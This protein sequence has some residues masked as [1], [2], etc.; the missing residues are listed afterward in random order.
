MQCSL[1]TAALQPGRSHS[2]ARVKL[3]VRPLST[4]RPPTS[5]GH[6]EGT[7]EGTSDKPHLET[8]SSLKLTKKGLRIGGSSELLPNHF[9]L[10]RPAAVCGHSKIPQTSFCQNL[11]FEPQSKSLKIKVIGIVAKIHFILRHRE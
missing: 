7:S 4:P 11:K 5:C 6:L 9:L 8:T 1:P 3:V 2:G 10:N